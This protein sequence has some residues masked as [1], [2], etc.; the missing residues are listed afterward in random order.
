M[1]YLVG[2]IVEIR[3][4]CSYA[5]YKG[6]SKNAFIFFR[7]LVGIHSNS[8]PSR[9]SFPRKRESSILY[10][11]TQPAVYILASKRNGT[12]YTGITNDLC[13]RVWEHK[14]DLIDGFTQKYCVH[15]LVYFELHEDITAAIRC[16]KQI[17]KWNRDWKIHLIEEMNPQW[18]DL[19]ED[20][21]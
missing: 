4:G 15:K 21:L 14:N 18:Q 2:E 11:M 3:T 13:R 5:S 17:K 19:Y 7:L 9:S 16:E 6:W 1:N 20:I 10:F 8:H 12:L